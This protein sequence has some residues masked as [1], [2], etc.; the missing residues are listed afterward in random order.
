MRKYFTH[1]S[2]WVCQLYSGKDGTLVLRLFFIVSQLDI[3]AF[4]HYF[5][6][7]LKVVRHL[8]FYLEKQLELKVEVHP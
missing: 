7:F 8:I 5:Y 6:P 4:S 2:I 3:S 1:L